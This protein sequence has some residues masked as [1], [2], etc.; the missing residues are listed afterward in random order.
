[1][2]S[3]TASPALTAPLSAQ[4]HVGHAVTAPKRCCTAYRHRYVVFA[5][6]DNAVAVVDVAS[7]HSTTCS[8][9]ARW[10]AQMRVFSLSA[11]E[12]EIA[13]VC[14]HPERDVVCVGTQR[15][16]LYV[17]SLSQ[18]VFADSSK[19][20]RSVTGDATFGATF[21]FT[22]G[23]NYF[24]F[25]S[26]LHSRPSDPTPYRLS[27][28]CLDT[29]ALLWRGAMAPLESMCSLSYDLSFAACQDG[30]VCLFTVQAHNHNSSAKAAAGPS[31][32]VGEEGSSG[33]RSHNERNRLIVLSRNCS[34]VEELLGA[35][36][37]HCIASPAEG[38]DS[39]LALTTNG[40]LVAF[41]A[42]SG[43]VTRWMDC[44]V[45]VATGLCVYAGG[46]L[47]LT[48]ELARFFQ[49]GSWEFQGKVKLELPAGLASHGSVDGEGGTAADVFTSAVAADSNTL[50][51]FH[52]SGAMSFHTVEL[53]AGT[54][55]RSLH[56]AAFFPNLFS[57]CTRHS[58]SGVFVKDT[59]SL[60]WLVVSASLW[61]WWT[62]RHLLFLSSASGALVAAYAVN[63]TC[64]TLHPASGAIILFDTQ[65]RAL[66][67]YSR[68]PT[69]PV[70]EVGVL[71]CA[72]A[73]KA[74]EE[75][76]IVSLASSPTGESFYALVSLPKGALPPRLRRYRCGWGTV[77]KGELSEKSFYMD[78][79]K[80]PDSVGNGCDVVSTAESGA[81]MSVSLP[82]GTHTILVQ[83]SGYAPLTT[84]RAA[85]ASSAFAA[86]G[87]R[88]V[89]V[90]QNTI[91]SVGLSGP[92]ERAS[93]PAYT[94]PDTIQRVL[95]CRGGLLI[96]ASS[97]CTFVQ[98]KG[99]SSF[100]WAAK[101]LFSSAPGGKKG[102]PAAVRAVAAAVAARRADVAVVCVDRAVT[103]WQLSDSPRLLTSC[104]VGSAAALM[105]ADVEEPARRICFYALGAAGVDAYQRDSLDLSFSAPITDVVLGS[106]A[107]SLKVEEKKAEAKPSRPAMTS[108]TPR[109]ATAVPPLPLP[110][111]ASPAS[112]AAA[113]AAEPSTT[114]TRRIARTPRN[115]ASTL[116]NRSKTLA[117]T[118]RQRR[119]VSAGAPSSRQLSE[120]FDELTGF[121]ARQKQE[122]QG[123]EHPR[124]P[125][126]G[127]VK[128]QS[129]RQLHADGTQL[130]P[131]AMKPARPPSGDKGSNS[132]PAPAT[133]PRAAQ[134]TVS[135][136]AVMSVS[137]VDVSALTVDSQVLRSA[138]TA[139]VAS[140][141][142]NTQGQEGGEGC[143]DVP[144]TTG[145]DRTTPSSS[146]PLQW[147]DSPP[148]RGDLRRGPVGAPTR[149][150]D[151]VL[152]SSASTLTKSPAPS[153]G[154]SADREPQRVAPEPSSPP[155]VQLYS[156]DALKRQQQWQPQPHQQS[157]EASDC[158]SF[159]SEHFTMQARHLRESLLHIKEL[160]EQ[161]EM[162]ESSAEVSVV[163]SDE[164]DLDEL[165]SLLTTVAAQLHQR[166]V[167][168]SAGGA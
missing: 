153:L 6:T 167:R 49:V 72:T 47:V 147:F 122:N 54:Q 80:T 21:L 19:L 14:G 18:P 55:R 129:Q 78:C 140:A 4:W 138:V 128:N 50:I 82:A 51:L 29:R 130:V 37:V 84:P 66:V 166:Q 91:V 105:M 61:C 81:A 68:T 58:R 152:R 92:R 108:P 12:E 73:G 9:E 100:R 126:P 103:V 70:A 136:S 142:A 25:S 160:L 146:S 90:Q 161:S 53:R 77:G 11:A 157:A 63:S 148:Q 13:F 39:Y 36:Y 87:D 65:R 145:G 33:G 144:A 46:S 76:A 15:H 34:A 74:D 1:M 8:A 85:G 132:L 101:P 24:A 120:R 10:R 127:G 79:M 143:I 113:A 20:P 48:G 83:T 118:R 98:W 112:P 115:L 139:A 67:A 59:A 164:A 97:S 56:R 69:S 22:E 40:F 123:N 121:Y 154:L 119:T 162:A 41:H 86:E 32:T 149:A 44:K 94:H 150:D 109:V 30:K 165:A 151:A 2:A 38:E 117:E 155:Q 64:A 107:T 52:R 163:P 111:K 158:N 134:A 125:R 43:S 131:T 27:L 135:E 28:W 124:T 96:L 168:R 45:P 60:Q 99:S 159:I 95:P 137:A 31:S 75:E 116:T 93:A 5:A 141:A 88:L 17:T 26:L 3:S 110:S 42:T 7:T 114:F 89:A 57:M 23:A 16:G 106:P 102:G 35:H 71:A 156:A 133:A 62:P 104:T